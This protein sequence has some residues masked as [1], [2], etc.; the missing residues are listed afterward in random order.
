ML[1][2][3]LSA[4]ATSNN[5]PLSIQS[6][7]ANNP[8]L[9]MV[10]V[11]TD[12][13]IG[14]QVRWGGIIVNVS[15]DNGLSAMEIE[16][17]PLNRY[18]LPLINLRS[19]GMFIAQTDQFFDPDLYQQGLLITFSGTIKSEI[20]KTVNRKE[21]FLPIITITDSHLWPYTIS[22]GKA[23]PIIDARARNARREATTQ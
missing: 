4:C 18:G 8:L 6:P 14:K 15:S 17:F 1:T 12:N 5:V 3:L 20:T 19:A 7:P 23:Y 9:R 21:Y 22:N 13:F 11:D 16:Y 10:I 2:I